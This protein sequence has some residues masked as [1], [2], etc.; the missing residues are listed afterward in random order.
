VPIAT[1]AT[2][3]ALL[4]QRC[5]FLLTVLDADEYISL[6]SIIQRQ[7]FYGSYDDRRRAII[8]QLRQRKSKL[9]TS[10]LEAELIANLIAV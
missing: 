1:A 2:Y 6:T 8:R 9:S 7:Q 4:A 10:A 5:P 3:I